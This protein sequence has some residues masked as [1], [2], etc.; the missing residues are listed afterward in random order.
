LA[1]LSAT[2][3]HRS[4]VALHSASHPTSRFQRWH[5]QSSRGAI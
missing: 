5:S 1:A 2:C 3:A 4:R